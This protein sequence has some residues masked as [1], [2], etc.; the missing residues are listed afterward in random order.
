MTEPT[1]TPPRALRTRPSISVRPA[2]V[3]AVNG[4]ALVVADAVAI[5]GPAV[6][7][8]AGAVGLGSAALAATKLRRV[9]RQTA[10]GRVRTRAA[11]PS[12]A[13]RGLLGRLRPSRGASLGSGKP[14]TGSRAMTR[15]RSAVADKPTGRIAR[16]RKRAAESPSGRKVAAVKAKT[17]AATRRARDKARAKAER[18]RAKAVK[19][20]ALRKGTINDPGVGK[21]TKEKSGTKGKGSTG[22]RGGINNTVPDAAGTKNASRNKKA[23]TNVPPAAPAPAVPVPGVITVQPIT[24]GAST[25]AA[26]MR[27]LLDLAEQMQAIAAQYDPEGMLEVVD[28]Y[29]QLPEVLDGFASALRVFHGK[30]EES[31]PLKPI[32]V[33]L[34]GSTARHQVATARAADEIYPAII[35]LHREQLEELEDAKAA[36]WDHSRN[37]G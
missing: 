5:G 29:R 2:A 9:R 32:I 11:R 6:W 12:G 34:I 30:A 17:R 4:T 8:V 25:M 14:S 37:K 23:P 36:M 7:A 10:G 27:R 16:A 20:K 13:S 21:K 18:A 15:G 35:T 28:D 24:S 33:E 22:K 19:A 3:G 31:Y 1:P 26:T